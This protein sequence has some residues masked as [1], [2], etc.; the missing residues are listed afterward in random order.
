M[1]GKFVLV[2]GNHDK[3][4]NKTHTPTHRIVLSHGGVFINLT[5]RPQDTII[6]DEDHYYPLS[7]H[8]H[9]HGAYKTKEIE[10]EGKI[11]L[12]INVS[13]ETKNYY[14][15]SFDEVMGIY[16]KWLNTHPKKKEIYNWNNE[17]RNN[18]TN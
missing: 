10:R 11:A 15:Y 8:G 5:H 9:V 17:R 1:N 16:S 18:G 7:I 12:L 14:P 3:R 6:E 4:S 13:V 2:G